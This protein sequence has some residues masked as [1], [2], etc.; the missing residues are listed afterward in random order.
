MSVSV[1]IGTSLN[2][3]WEL[4]LYSVN[5]EHKKISLMPGDGLLYKGCEICHWRSPM[6]GKLENSVR[7]FL[8]LGELYYH[9]IFFHYVLS[10]GHRSHHA[11]DAAL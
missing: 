2:K 9:Q 4:Q 10:E 1:H 5:G 6:P 3:K 7:K 11:F 8:N